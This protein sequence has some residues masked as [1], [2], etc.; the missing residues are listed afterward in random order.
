MNITPIRTS[1]LIPRRSTGDII[2]DGIVGA[3]SIAA[4]VFGGP[5]L[6][7]AVRGLSSTPGAGGFDLSSFENMLRQQQE[8]QMVNTSVNMRSNISKLDHETRMAAVRNIRP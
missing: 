6:G 1:S 4:T 2:L 3:G 7:A 5:G 8:F